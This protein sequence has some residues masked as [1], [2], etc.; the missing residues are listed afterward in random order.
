MTHH[1]VTKTVYTA[2]T[3]V[4]FIFF[5]CLCCLFGHLCNIRY[6]EFNLFSSFVILADQLVVSLGCML[7]Q[8]YVLNT[9]ILI[10]S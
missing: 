8:M 3:S 6:C 10:P 1:I 5:F 2:I 4:L 9:K 7:A